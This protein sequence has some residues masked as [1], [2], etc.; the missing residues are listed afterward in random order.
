MVASCV[1]AVSGTPGAGKTSLCTALAEAGWQVLSLADLAQT[2]GCLGPVDED[3]GAAPLMFTVWRN[4]GGA[5]RRSV[6]GGR[7]SRPFFGG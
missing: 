4:L 1:L 5:H 2:Y 6:A 3:D 7:S